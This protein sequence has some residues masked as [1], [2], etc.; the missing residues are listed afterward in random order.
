MKI[1]KWLGLIQAASPYAVPPGAAT[2][3]VNAMSLTPGQLTVRGG[4]KT[5][6]ETDDKLHS[7]WGLSV[8]PGQSDLILG[9]SD[10]GFLWKYKGAGTGDTSFID[11]K[12]FLGDQPVS[13]CQGRR[14]EVYLYQGYGQPGMVMGANGFT[15]PVGL[16]SPAEKPGITIDS[17]ASYYVARIDLTDVGN[18]YHLP[19][20]VYIGPPP[21]QSNALSASTGTPTTNNGGLT[22]DWG[23]VPNQAGSNTSQYLPDSPAFT[24]GTSGR[25]AKAICR[26]GNAQVSEVEVTDGGD[27]Y[28]S[29]P[30]VQFK[31]QP[32]L[33][34]TGTGAAAALKLKSG[35][36]Q[37]DPDTGVVFWEIFEMPY[38]WWMCFDEYERQGNGFIVP[39]TGGKGS[40]AKAI[41][42]F[43]DSFWS[44]YKCPGPQSDGTDLT[45]LMVTVQVY[46][47]GTGYQP[48]DEI[49][50]TLHVASSFF[51]GTWSPTGKLG[52]DCRTTSACQLKARGFCVSDPRCPDK[53]TIIQTN[54]LKQ[55]QIDPIPANSGKGYMTPPT[56]TLEDG[57]VLQTEVDC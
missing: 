47:F 38:Y 14:G 2:E 21:G 56:F 57:D 37:G 7:M 34:V 12:D 8:G 10:R 19:P 18:G 26:I 31:D 17:S 55:R 25:Q 43:P 41:F 44:R 45:D 3:Q 29:T 5:M 30:C 22:F 36:A 54:T 50:A 35:F 16:Q 33:A 4:M 28:T 32:G 23:V 48:G 11:S 39:A 13:F 49:V 27:G 46:D 1:N 20:S 51:A 15:R 40:G 24:P 53:L 6:F 9:V 52:P 42:I